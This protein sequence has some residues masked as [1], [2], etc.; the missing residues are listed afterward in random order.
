[1]FKGSGLYFRVFC[2][3]GET[4]TTDFHGF[5]FLTILYYVK[6]FYIFLRIF[7]PF[8]HTQNLTLGEVFY[9]AV[10]IIIRIK[11][12]KNVQLLTNSY[13]VPL[14]ASSILEIC[15]VLNLMC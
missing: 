6:P 9:S 1:M 3:F 4:I 8:D 7:F 2:Y 12:A 13:F 5:V 14:F 15:P 10:G 11:W